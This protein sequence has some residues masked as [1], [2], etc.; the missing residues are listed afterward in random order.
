MSHSRMES[1]KVKD[2]ASTADR[3][4][5]AIKL[6]MPRLGA[7]LMLVSACVSVSLIYLIFNALT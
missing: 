2:F 3:E 6:V 5:L 1:F 4:E 7:L